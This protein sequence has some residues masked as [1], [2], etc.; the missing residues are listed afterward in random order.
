MKVRCVIYLNFDNYAIFLP[1]YH[2][3]CIQKG[4]VELIKKK[5]EKKRETSSPRL[6]HYYRLANDYNGE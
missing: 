5:K 3:L 6:G 2:S 1:S 4:L